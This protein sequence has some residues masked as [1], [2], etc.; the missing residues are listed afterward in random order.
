LNLPTE[1]PLPGSDTQC[2][3]F[4]LGDGA[5]PLSKTMMKPFGG[6]EVT[7]HQRIFNYRFKFLPFSIL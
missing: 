5:F 7:K 4:F 1:C 6:K 3:Y 2:P